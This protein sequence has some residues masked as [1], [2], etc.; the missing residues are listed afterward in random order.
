M[1]IKWKCDRFNKYEIKLLNKFEKMHLQQVAHKERLHSP[2]DS[3]IHCNLSLG[4][5]NHRSDISL[6]SL[7]LQHNHLIY[8]MKY[9]IFYNIGTF[10][11]QFVNYLQILERWLPILANC[12]LI[13]TLQCNDFKSK[14]IF[15]III[16][17][18]YY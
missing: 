18:I 11:I 16:F 17:H 8:K 2:L 15:K 5:G 3:S 9:L 1:I 13:E 7:F 4:Y 10:T 12:L 14:N 6:I